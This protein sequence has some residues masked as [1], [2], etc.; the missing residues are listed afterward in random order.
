MCSSHTY[1]HILQN[2]IYNLHWRCIDRSWYLCLLCLRHDV[3]E[4]FHNKRYMAW[5][6]EMLYQ[7]SNSPIYLRNTICLW[8]HWRI[9]CLKL[10]ML[11][12]TFFT[13]DC[14]WQDTGR[15]GAPSTH[16]DQWGIRQP[17]S[18]LP[19]DEGIKNK[20]HHR[21]Q[22]LQGVGNGPLV[23]HE[24]WGFK[25]L[26]APVVDFFLLTAHKQA[27]EECGVLHHD[28]KT[29]VSDSIG[30]SNVGHHQ[31]Q[32]QTNA[33]WSLCDLWSMVSHGTQGT[34]W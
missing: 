3:R 33:R 14:H 23:L 17:Y 21:I 32:T 25:N 26:E 6:E 27:Y 20:A 15:H 4:A 12:I 5:H 34:S 29:L 7:G 2:L 9:Y 11:L 30:F 8:A 18:S 19:A 31:H 28:C 24:R 16:T 22:E 1:A 13:H 10:S